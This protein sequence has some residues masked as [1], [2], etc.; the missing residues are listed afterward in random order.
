MDM[1]ITATP[2][3]KEKMADGILGGHGDTG[4]VKFYTQEP[5]S[6]ACSSCRCSKMRLAAVKMS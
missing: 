2:T 5:V 4:R 6:E 1:Y 3:A